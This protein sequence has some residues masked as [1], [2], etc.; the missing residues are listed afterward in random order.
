MPSS[1]ETHTVVKLSRDL[2]SRLRCHAEGWQHNYARGGQA[3]GNPDGKILSLERIIA[4]LLERDTAHRKRS[5]R[6]R[7][8]R[9]QG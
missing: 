6:K 3:P 2:V 7:R 5:N 8:V 1:R 9:Y 4:I